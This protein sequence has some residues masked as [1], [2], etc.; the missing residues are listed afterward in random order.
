MLHEAKASP[1][2]VPSTQIKVSSARIKLRTTRKTRNGGETPFKTAT[3]HVS[4]PRPPVLLHDDGLPPRLIQ[5]L[6]PHL[7]VLDLLQQLPALVR[8]RQRH[9]AQPRGRLLHVRAASAGEHRDHQE[10]AALHGIA[11][12]LR[13]RQALDAE[14]FVADADHRAPGRQ[15]PATAQLAELH[16]HGLPRNTYR[17]HRCV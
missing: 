1:T 2:H 3:V 14:R 16:V 11:Q 7:G 10:V 13:G 9:V 8:L 4:G 15:P 12:W 5:A 6:A 17:P